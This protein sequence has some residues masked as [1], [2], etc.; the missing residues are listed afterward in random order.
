MAGRGYNFCTNVP[1]TDNVRENSASG[2]KNGGKSG[3]NRV[4]VTTGILA[5]STDL[6]WFQ[7]RSSLSLLYR[8]SVPVVPFPVV[9]QPNR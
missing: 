4:I 7:N 9:R 6:R 2:G 8:E 1:Y 3:A 5:S